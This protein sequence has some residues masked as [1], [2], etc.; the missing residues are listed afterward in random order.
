MN[1]QSDEKKNR[2]TSKTFNF[3]KISNASFKNIQ[4]GWNM[5]DSMRKE[6]EMR[7]EK[8]SLHDCRL[9]VWMDIENWN[10]IKRNH[11]SH[12]SIF[13]WFGQN[14]DKNVAVDFRP[15]LHGQNDL[16]ATQTFNCNWIFLN[17]LNV[18]IEMIMG[19]HFK[20]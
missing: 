14:N 3:D 15:V 20:I 11:S 4:K 8:N 18:Y 17:T 5:L 19:N 10:S 16:E 2:F 12:H 7:R 9:C 1:G 6:E 13:Y